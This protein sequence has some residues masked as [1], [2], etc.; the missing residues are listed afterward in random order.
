LQ[1]IT[2]SVLA[3]AAVAFILYQAQEIRALRQR[4]ATI[5]LLQEQERALTNRVRDLQRER[6]RATNA[7]AAL[8]EDRAAS[9]KSPSEV[10]KLRG[11]VG[12]LRQE[13]TT[14]AT[15]SGLSKVTAN[16]ESRKMLRDQQK[17]GMSMIYKGFAQRAKLTS[18]Q[19]EKLNDLLADHIMENV[20]H[21]T[22]V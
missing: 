22:A 1:K 5:N 17:M 8:S 10:L 14:M 21:V 3:I 16:P 9:K 20:G 7:L 12:R 6:D 4:E 19:T 11:E 15:S 13:N 18:D 2:L